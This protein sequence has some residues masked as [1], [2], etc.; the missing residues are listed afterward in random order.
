M[1]RGE[2]KVDV[3]ELPEEEKSPATAK[4]RKEK[5]KLV[6][7]PS[8]VK[9]KPTA[10]RRE[11]DGDVAVQEVTPPPSEVPMETDLVGQK[12][13]E[14]G[15]K[16]S[17]TKQKAEEV[18]PSVVKP[19]NEQEQSGQN[20]KQQYLSKDEGR[21]DRSATPRC[22]A[23]SPEPRPAGVPASGA[24][25][26]PPATPSATTP[27]ATDKSEG[28]GKEASSP[29]SS[30]ASESSSLKPG[31]DAPKPVDSSADSG[32]VISEK[33]KSRDAKQKQ[34]ERQKHVGVKGRAAPG[35]APSSRPAKAD[36]NGDK[37]VEEKNSSPSNIPSKK[38]IST[39]SDQCEGGSSQ[40]RKKSTFSADGS[41]S[42]SS[43]QPENPPRDAA[44]NT[45][46]NEASSLPKVVQP[47]DSVK[48]VVD[49]ANATGK[50]TSSQHQEETQ[51][52]WKRVPSL[53]KPVNKVSG[54]LPSS[55]KQQTSN[56]SQQEK[57]QH[58]P[59]NCSGPKMLSPQV[60]N[61]T[62]AFPFPPTSQPCDSDKG[63]ESKESSAMNGHDER[64]IV[65]VNDAS[66]SPTGRV[67][68]METSSIP[69][70]PKELVLNATPK[71]FTVDSNAHSA[72][73]TSS[74]QPPLKKEKTTDS[75]SSA[76]T[77]SSSCSNSSVKQDSSHHKKASNSKTSSYSSAV[78][79]AV[80]QR[81]EQLM[82]EKDSKVSRAAA[83][84]NNFIGDVIAKNKQPDNIRSLEKP[85]KISNAGVGTKG[86]SDLKNAFENPKPKKTQ[87]EKL[88]IMRRNSKKMNLEGCT[89]GLK[90]TDAKSVFESKKQPETP[91]ILRRNSTNS[92]QQPKWA[93]AK[94]DGKTTPVPFGKEPEAPKK[95]GA[96]TEN[97]MSQSI[98]KDND[99]SGQ[100]DNGTR[101]IL[102]KLEDKPLIEIAAVAPPL[103]SAVVESAK[104]VRE[105]PAKK[106]AVNGTPTTN[107]AGNVSLSKRSVKQ[108]EK[109]KASS[110]RQNEKK[111]STSKSKET[112]TSAKGAEPSSKAKPGSSPKP[113]LRLGKQSKITEKTKTAEAI[114]NNMC[115]V[116]P[117]NEGTGLVLTV[118]HPKSPAAKENSLKRVE[119]PP[120]PTTA[121]PVEV[122]SQSEQDAKLAAVGVIS[123]EVLKRSTVSKLRDQGLG[124]KSQIQD[125]KSLPVTPI[126]ET[127]RGKEPASK[128]APTSP[129]IAGLA[130]TMPESTA[131]LE[132]QMIKAPQAITP[133]GAILAPPPPE[134][135]SA[136]ETKASVP[137]IKTIN[138]EESNS[139][140][141]LEVVKS[142]L[143]RVPHAP[144]MGKKKKGDV[145]DSIDKVFSEGR[146]VEKDKVR[147]ESPREEE[148]DEK[149][150]KTTAAIETV[151]PTDLAA[152]STVLPVKSQE[153]PG[154]SIPSI[155]HEDNSAKIVGPPSE[156][157]DQ[158]Q[159]E[160]E[161]ERF[162]PITVEPPKVVSAS[163]TSDAVATTA[164]PSEISSHSKPP[165]A[166]GSGANSVARKKKEHYIPI[167]V[168]GRGTIMPPTPTPVEED[169]ERR[170]TFHPNSLSRQ[171]WGS[172]KKRMS[173]AYSD[174][175]VSDDEST[176][177]TSPFGGLQRYSSL[178]K[179]GLDQERG[180]G[181]AGGGA[182]GSGS[183]SGYGGGGA[184]GQLRRGRPPFSMQR[185]ESFSSEEGEDDFGDDD[186]F[187][188]MT[189]ENLFSTLLSRVRNLT[190]RIHDEHDQH[191]AWQ[192]TQRIVNHP[193]N[194]GGTHARL[195]R[196]ARRNSTKSKRERERSG[197]S[198]PVS[199]SRQSSVREDFPRA[200]DEVGAGAGAM[201]GPADRSL[202]HRGISR[203]E[204]GSESLYS[205]AAAA[206]AG[207]LS[208]KRYDKSDVPSDL[209]GSI[210]ITSKQRLRPG[211]L[212][213][214]HSIPSSTGS[215]TEP[216]SPQHLQQRVVSRDAN[217]LTRERT[218]PITI[219]TKR[220]GNSSGSSKGN[221]ISVNPTDLLGPL[222]DAQASADHVKSPRPYFSQQNSAEDNAGAEPSDRSS[223]TQQRRVSRFLRP[224]FYETSLEEKA[225]A[226][227]KEVSEKKKATSSA[228]QEQQCLQ[229]AS[230]PTATTTR[231]H[232][233]GNKGAT[234]TTATA[235]A[236]EGETNKSNKLLHCRHQQEDSTCPPRTFSNP[237]SA[238]SEGQ[239]LSRALTLKRQGESAKEL[240]PSLPGSPTST[241]NASSSSSTPHALPS[242]ISSSS[243]SSPSKPILNNVLSN[244]S[245]ISSPV[246]FSTTLP[247]TTTTSFPPRDCVSTPSPPSRLA[248]TISTASRP[249]MSYAVRPFRRLGGRV[250]DASSPL[251]GREDL[252]PRAASP[253]PP[254]PVIEDEARDVVRPLMVVSPSPS[255]SQPLANQHVN[256]SGDENARGNVAG[257]NS[258]PRR[259]ILPYGGAKSDG[260]LNKHAFIT[261][262]I[263]AAAERRRKESYSRSSTSELLPVE[264]VT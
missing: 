62:T 74:V 234:T 179:H 134:P 187:R 65:D 84:W 181:G 66:S 161:R 162:I 121:T 220:S 61:A 148:P 219:A 248:S 264:K 132:Q 117:E 191:V 168:E 141:K 92:S 236:S 146:K 114:G 40:M 11:E 73:N 8:M 27:V 106:P 9:A 55:P 217:R 225:Q 196:N 5:R 38:G 194:P 255:S 259:P 50:K 214:P 137:K 221:N 64:K 193:L 87:D 54:P 197:A 163:V 67:Q 200:Y 24:P 22:R 170:D 53:P 72:P 135:P 154:L 231:S 245:R 44:N 71:P 36:R 48:H 45:P 56:V 143:K 113:K 112:P 109:K 201:L 25:P 49:P 207:K 142:S 210:S 104:E 228:Q 131:L 254:C 237:K 175:S 158:Q 42:P 167:T 102:A 263:I 159:A 152:K 177:F 6:E 30:Q 198:T 46:M 32:I 4:K 108:E 2:C 184:F 20:Q 35:R 122:L 105:V 118:A 120:A 173:S 229:G 31:E 60:A 199:F 244:A 129:E 115:T 57:Q 68:R 145:A 171:R 169:D 130:T 58:L 185:V 107:Q 242:L 124:A 139:Q 208:Q 261:C 21:R 81:Q 26:P 183:G 103:P 89:P 75:V 140:N 209:S 147:K 86:M 204:S 246:P 215:L 47:K 232:V 189:A 79:M 133:G 205:D 96:P 39:T 3:S 153:T 1:G 202:F 160:G 37:T 111:E 43:Q 182:S 155:K 125:S 174:S 77:L 178:G 238:P 70:S 230:L 16:V 101:P 98:S 63:S 235:L 186:G 123:R 249:V 17:R 126:K 144:A 97:D 76:V 190:K 94:E 192:Q 151:L 223:E 34:E 100:G 180:P 95:Q 13:D 206:A 80:A 256:V 258:L 93:K 33:S 224:D 116:E 127:P 218:I 250:P 136:N 23:P 88:A 260:L 14:E 247:T 253:L 82:K 149:Q 166:S 85:K 240:P 83:Y 19:Q 69:S 213:T 59:A 10:K 165:L 128:T 252:L 78:E 157:R 52:K 91:S 150:G 164:T 156:T 262:N 226:K 41:S 90:V 216:A 241:T 51:G 15:A 211:Y 18:A 176:F 110:K 257:N 7:T 172:R 138:T 243:S 203:D 195:E 28:K 239:F 251:S 99:E 29:P 222:S 233:L 119:A 188:E 227:V 12:N 212:P